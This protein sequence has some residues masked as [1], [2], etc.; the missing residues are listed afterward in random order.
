[1]LC[2]QC[3]TELPERARFCLNCGAPAPQMESPQPSTPPPALDF[4][5]PAL[6]GGM[7]LGVLSSIPVISAGNCLCCM[8]VLGGGAFGAFLLMKQR[9]TG[10]I[11]YGDGA[12]V[13]VMSGLFGAFV[14]TLISIPLKMLTARFFVGQR[15]AMERALQDAGVEG[16]M[17]DLI[18]R[19]ASPEIS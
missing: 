10:G 11:S 17:R 8:W 12:F 16:G 4:T 5:Q 15:E 19:M 7:L 13:G 9:P 1:M 6:A 3:G 14:A 2:S 18:L